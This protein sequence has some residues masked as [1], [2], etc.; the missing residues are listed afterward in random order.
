MNCF[1][2]LAAEKKTERN[3]MLEASLHIICLAIGLLSHDI[4]CIFY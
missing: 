1:Y 4:I 3:S 2:I